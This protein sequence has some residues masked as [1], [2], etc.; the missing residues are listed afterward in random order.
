MVVCDKCRS[1]TKP[2]L[3]LRVAVQKPDPSSG[4]VR[5]EDLHVRKVELCADCVP[6]VWDAMMAAVDR[7]AGPNA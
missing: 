3:D 7:A 4:R 5:P 1:V 2:A 6:L